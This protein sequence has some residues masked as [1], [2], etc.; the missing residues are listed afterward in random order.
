V[1]ES[2]EA[3]VDGELTVEELADRAGLTVRTVRFYASEGLLPAPR[4]RGRLAI[5]DN[6]HQLRLDLIRTLQDHGYTLSAIQRVLIRIPQD[7]PPAVYAVQSAVLAPWLRDEEVVD[8]DRAEL[9]RRFG[10]A[11]TDPQWDFLVAIGAVEPLGADRY[12]ATPV[13]VTHAIELLALPVPPELLI[14]STR[15]ISEH[16]TAVAD[17]LTD[18]FAGVVWGPYRRGELDDEQVLQLLERLRPLA[19]HGLVG[20]FTRAADQAAHRRLDD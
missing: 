6:R 3:T 19:L 16:A 14:D 12:R 4:R 9:Q 15:I 17:G 11:F 13:M 2:G 10:T 20:A 18:W 8:L 5:Y 7:A 1:G